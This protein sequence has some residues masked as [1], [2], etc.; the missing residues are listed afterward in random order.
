M[1]SCFLEHTP[2]Y[3]RVYY[4]K[5]LLALCMSS[6][7]C[8]EHFKEV[9]NN[10]KPTDLSNSSL[11]S[12]CNRLSGPCALLDTNCVFPENGRA[13]A[14][15]TGACTENSDPSVRYAAYIRPESMLMEGMLQSLGARFEGKPCQML[16]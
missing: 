5:A 11:E 6:K 2:R 10:T 9:V 4:P 1:S 15:C 12:G 8:L 16:C 14:K 3:E 13:T 7:P